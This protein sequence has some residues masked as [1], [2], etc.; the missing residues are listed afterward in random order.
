MATKYPTKNNRVIGGLYYICPFC[1]ASLDPGEICDCRKVRYNTSNNSY[2][3]EKRGN[4]HERITYS[5]D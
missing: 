3:K 2:N 5:R 1:D 4:K